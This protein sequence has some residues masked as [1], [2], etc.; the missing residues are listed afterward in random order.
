M[1]AAR[2]PFLLCAAF[3]VIVLGPGRPGYAELVYRLGAVE[4]TGVTDRAEDQSAGASQGTDG[5]ETIQGRVQVGHLGRLTTDQ[6]SY[7]IMATTWFQSAPKV[8]LTHALSLASD[9]QPGPD[10]RLMLAGTAMLT[11]P[12]MLDSAAASDPQ[13]AGARPVGNREFLTLQAHEA[14]SWEMGAA[15]SMGQSLEGRLYR[16]IADDPDPTTNKSATFDAQVNHQWQQDSAGLLCSLGTIASSNTKVLDQQTGQLVASNSSS[17]FADTTLSWKHEWTP[18]LTHEATAGVFVLRTDRTRVLPAG[19]AG[20]VW[21]HFEHNAQLAAG[22]SADSNIYVGAAYERT[23]ARLRVDL[24][25]NRLDTLRLLAEA[26]LEHDTTTAGATGVQGSAN[27]FVG[28]LALHWQPGETVVY[29]LEYLRRDQRASAVEPGTT[30]LFTSLDRQTVM[31][32]IEANY[33][34]EP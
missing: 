28:R 25:V 34:R 8:Y 31:F 14:L 12:S 20:V 5:F 27:I 13:S 29:G 26:N 1:V 2:F 16:P 15:W 7:A 4:S 11:Q 19:S 18:D 17:E 33:P 6:L 9:I 21:R 24:G 30:S 32:T 23:Y 22:R 10:I 3:A